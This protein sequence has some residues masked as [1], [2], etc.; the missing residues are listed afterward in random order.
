MR[1]LSIRTTLLGT[2][3]ALA[4]LLAAG[5]AAPAPLAGPN[6]SA[7][8]GGHVAPSPII[9][10]Q[11]SDGGGAGGAGGSGDSGGSGGSGGGSGGSGGDSGGSGGSGGCSSGGG[12]G[13]WRVGAR[14]R[15]LVRCDW[16]APREGPRR[17]SG[18]IP[19]AHR[20]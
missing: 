17:S 11:A 20:R 7:G 1:P 10:A 4:I 8:P 14:V 19:A 5:Q 6:P 9:L 18:A 3:S 2:A 13:V 15:R 12:S 16:A